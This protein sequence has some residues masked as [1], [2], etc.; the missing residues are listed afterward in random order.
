MVDR[1]CCQS[2][3]RAKLSSGQPRT[4]FEPDAL[5]DEADA[6]QRVFWITSLMRSIVSPRFAVQPSSSYFTSLMSES[7]GIL[8]GRLGRSRSW[9]AVAG[10]QIARVFERDAEA[11]FAV[12]DTLED[13]RGAVKHPGVADQLCDLVPA[14]IATAPQI[15]EHRDVRIGRPRIGR[16]G[17]GDVAFPLR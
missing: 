2:A 7:F 10:P 16:I 13:K 5:R 14:G 8:P 6:P 15:D 17:E 9:G 3:P 4:R 1:N 11:I 12:A